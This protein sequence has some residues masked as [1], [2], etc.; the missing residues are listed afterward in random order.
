MMFWKK[1]KVTFNCKLPEVLER[2]PIIPAREL[3]PN[4]WR[5]AAIEYKQRVEQT[6]RHEQ[7]TGTI[8]CPG[9]H[10]IMQRGWILRS[11][12]DLTILTGNEP[13]RFEFAIPSSF[14]DYL[15]NTKFNHKLV[16]WFSANEP[17]LRV[18]LQSN[19]LQTLIKIT[20]PWSITV[21]KG[22]AVLMLPIPYPD[23]R[24]FTAHMGILEPG[25]FYD[26]SPI[27]EIHKKPGEL[28]IPAGTPL[29]QILVI[30][31]SDQDIVQQ[32][33]DQTSWQQELISRFRTTHTFTTRDY[34]DR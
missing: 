30:D 23:T 25:G 19:S 1:P 28:F 18:P 29:M 10:T 9:I 5:Q 16:K 31:H 14:T 8:K 7:I 17:A 32:V 34:N 20:T 33:Q 11:W 24:D 2:Y 6:G 21:P 12:F 3:R 13:D 27:I 15:T 26:V 22:L 4:W